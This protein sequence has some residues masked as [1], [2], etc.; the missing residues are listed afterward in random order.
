MKKSGKKE[1][2]F[3]NGFLYSSFFKASIE[4]GLSSVGLWKAFKKSNGYPVS[5]KKNLIAT[6]AWMLLR[7]SVIKMEY[8]L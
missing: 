5:I 1:P 2:I 8:G 4:S 6:E 3:I 7:K